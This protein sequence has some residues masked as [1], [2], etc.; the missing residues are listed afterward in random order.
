MRKVLLALSVGIPVLASSVF[1][2]AQ[3]QERRTSTPETSKSSKWVYSDSRHRL[4]YRPDE[5]GNRIMDFSYAGFGGGGAR[6][7]DV[8]VALTVNAIG[9]DNTAQIQ[10]S[11][12]AVSRMSLDANGFRGA[13]LLK[14]GTYELAGTLTIA[15]SGVVLRG[16]GSGEGGTTIKLTGEPHRFVRLEG[17]GEWQTEGDPAVIT[18]QY[19]PSGAE[20]FHVSDPSGFHRGDTVRIRRPVTEAW[21]HFMGMDTLVRNGKKQTW[22]APGTY[23]QTDRSIR[24]IQGHRVMLDAPLTDSLDAQYLTPE[25]AS[26]VHYSFPGRISRVG[27]E[28]LRVVAPSLD[29]PIGQSQYT[30]LQMASVIDGWARDIAVEETQN[31]ISV[32]E[33]AKRVTLDSI[34]IVHATAHTGAAAPADFSI[35]G[36][37]VLVNRCSVTGEGTW[38]LVTQAKVTGPIAV[39]NFTTNE[40]GVAP[41]QRWATGLLVDHSTFSNSTE[42]WPGVAFSNRK[43]YGSGHGWDVGW[44]VAWNVTS[45]YLLV[46]NP[47]GSMNWCIGC[48]GQA[49]SEPGIPSGI[50][51]EPN[52]TVLP[53]SLYLEQLRERLGETA[54]KNISYRERLSSH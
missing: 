29:V 51:D 43:T 18:D 50:F 53:A 13:V 39:V 40:R 42:K 25:G 11:I 36:T 48:T 3:L 32:S 31:A 45:P 2:A 52:A 8:R 4:R 26:M 35:A 6:L 20:S 49:V 19:V 34:R 47:P 46:Q 41:H 17:A 15:A 7:P 21:V 14:P 24:A 38:P 27:I 16:S 44:A 12:D 1:I 37:Q 33:T 10:A 5:R 28:N 22:I 54:L 9:S 30:L 23:I